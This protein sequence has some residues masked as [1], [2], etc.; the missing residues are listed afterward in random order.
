MASTPE[1]SIERRKG[2]LI[3]EVPRI[4]GQSTLRQCRARAKVIAAR[5]DVHTEPD[6]TS[7]DRRSTFG[8]PMRDP[9]GWIFTFDLSGDGPQEEA[10]STADG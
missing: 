1:P 9:Q 2:K 3:I 8:G 5:E 6:V 4:P 7:Y 10:W